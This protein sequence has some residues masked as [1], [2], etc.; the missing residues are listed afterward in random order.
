MLRA[1][2]FGDRGE[3]GTKNKDTT[4]EEGIHG[5]SEPD[6][7]ELE[8]LVEGHSPSADLLASSYAHQLEQMGMIQ[9]ATFVL[10]HLEGSLG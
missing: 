2:D 9:E 7:E 5:G 8:V 1:R 3:S 10:L 6:A 4:D